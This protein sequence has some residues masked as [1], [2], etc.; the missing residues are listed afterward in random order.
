MHLLRFGLPVLLA[1][2]AGLLLSLPAAGA[3]ASLQGDW[4][5]V[6]QHYGEGKHDFSD[7]GGEIAVE[8]R[9]DQGRLAGTVRWEHGQSP[10]P[11]YPTPDGPAQ[12][13]IT[14]RS[15]GPGLRWAEAR[16]AVPASG[17]EGTRL[18]VHERWELASPDR[19]ECTV[20]ITFEREGERRGRFVWHRVFER[21][22]TR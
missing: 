21:E 10:W 20:E 22:G 5:L 16:Y 17:P 2:T 6:E 15:S 14:D 19:A 8:F 1:G 18:L 4:S 9:I 7:R 12:V 3:D 11:A 13:E